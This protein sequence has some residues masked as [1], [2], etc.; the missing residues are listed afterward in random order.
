MR[1]S[2]GFKCINA[3]QATVAAE[4]HPEKEQFITQKTVSECRKGLKNNSS[5]NRKAEF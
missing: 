5:Q 1:N 4:S 2:F 3:L